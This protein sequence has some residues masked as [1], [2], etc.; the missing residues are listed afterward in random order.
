M[1]D[2]LIELQPGAAVIA[3]LAGLFVAGHVLNYLL[4]TAYWAFIDWKNKEKK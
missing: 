3:A 4:E 2:F 1:F